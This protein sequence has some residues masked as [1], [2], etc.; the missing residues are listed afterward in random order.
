MMPVRARPPP[1]NQKH[2]EMGDTIEQKVA[3]TMLAE[4]ITIEVGKRTFSVAQPTVATIIL[5]SASVSRLPH[6]KLDSEK[7]VEETLAVAKDCQALGEIA[8][9]LILGG[10]GCK[11]TERAV[12]KGGRRW[13]WG[14]F[15]T[16]RYGL[17]VDDPRQRLADEL[18]NTL[19]PKELFS[20]ISQIL[21]KL[22]IAD[23]FGLSTF[24]TEINLIR[25]TKVVTGAT[26]RGQ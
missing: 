12:L 20:L 14:I 2:T 10:E 19:S 23:F 24:L 17:E 18:L 25:P 8:A 13:L 16:R 7:V 1:Q 3:R 6:V 11:R 26:A 9:T 21:A 15:D 4:P 5:V 22:E